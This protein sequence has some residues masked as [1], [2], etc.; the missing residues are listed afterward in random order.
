MLAMNAGCAQTAQD[1]GSQDCCG[2]VNFA[3][4][5]FIV[6]VQRRHAVVPL[7]VCPDRSPEGGDRGSL[8]LIVVRGF[9]FCPKASCLDRAPASWQ[10]QCQ[11]SA[12]PALLLGLARENV[13]LRKRT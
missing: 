12:F 2:H 5:N 10:P 13:L 7:H 6:S 8:L 1:N 4:W 9:D 11:V 3:V